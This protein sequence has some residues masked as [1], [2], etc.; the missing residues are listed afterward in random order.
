MSHEFKLF[1][2]YLHFP[3]CRNLCNYCDF[4][5]KIPAEGDIEGFEQYLET[6]WEK[7]QAWITREG[8]DWSALKTF[9]LGGG[10]PSLWD[11]RG[12]EFLTQFFSK[13]GLSLDSQVEATMEV[14]PGTYTE[15]G[16]AAWREFG[17][18]RFSIGL[19]GLDQDFL[20]LLDRVHT[21]EESYQALEYFH[22]SNDNFS[23]DFML[24]LPYSEEK[25][26]D[27][28]KEL[29]EVLK[30]GPSHIS[31]YILTVKGAYPLIKQLPKEE[32][33]E[34]EYLEV[35]KYLSSQGFE[36]YEVSNFALRGK[37]SQHNLRYWNWETVAALGMSATG[38][39][40]EKS[41]RYKWKGKASEWMRE[42]LDRDAYRLEKIYMNMRTNR[43]IQW[44]DFFEGEELEKAQNL[45]Q[46]WEAR[47]LA[48]Q[49]L[50]NSMHFN[51]RGF[52]LLDNLIGELFSHIKTM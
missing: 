22:K 7:H 33:I 6:S 46:I 48:Q 17:I 12:A 1:S 39:L 43:G 50:N 34:R 37:E 27:I 19:Q 42:D 36:H 25:N 15:E 38:L 11:A 4:F 3:F 41:I 2:L 26:R 8:Y 47:G 40:A 9:Y 30:F 18:N 29:E 45:T 14:N 21:L 51:S 20:K 44:A 28:L 32:W 16:I 24:G 23:V 10:T 31:L 13:H 35:S 49:G 52:L 5:K